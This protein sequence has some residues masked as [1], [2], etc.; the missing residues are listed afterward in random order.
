MMRRVYEIDVLK[1]PHCGGRR[2]VLNFL[3]DPRV[4]AKILAHLGLPTEPPAIAAARPPPEPA[5]PFA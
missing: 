5:L 4:I 3:T 2:N 1:C